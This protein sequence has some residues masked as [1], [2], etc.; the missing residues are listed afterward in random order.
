MSSG[1]KLPPEERFKIVTMELCDVMIELL[2][3]Q[4][5]P[6]IP[7]FMVAIAKIYM[8]GLSNDTLIE[9]YIH[10]SKSHWDAVLKKDTEY[11]L[12][13]KVS[14]FGEL[15]QG[16]GPEMFSAFMSK[17]SK[18]EDVEMIWTF[19]QTFVKIAIRYIH[20]RRSPYRTAG[21]M[22]AYRTEYYSDINLTD[23]AQKFRVDLVFT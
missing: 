3:K 22:P 23:M 15:P 9:N 14:V 4:K 11:F 8:S 5:N 16:N 12:K 2:N 1:T 21:G 10:Y 7:P 17:G 18:P 20:N 6:V 19:Q 13:N